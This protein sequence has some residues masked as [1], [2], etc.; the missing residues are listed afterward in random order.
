MYVHTLNTIMRSSS[1]ILFSPVNDNEMIYLRN[2]GAAYFVKQYDN[3]CRNCKNIIEVFMVNFRTL[4][5]RNNITENVKNLNPF[6]DRHRKI[7]Y[8]LSRCIRT[9]TYNLSFNDVITIIDIEMVDTNN[10]LPMYNIRKKSGGL[11][12]IK[13]LS[14]EMVQEILEKKV[15]L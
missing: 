15:G 8:F 3:N 2:E 10:Y 13:N 12:E 9:Y 6:F 14:Y 5:D 11:Q 7:Q 4:L 1:P